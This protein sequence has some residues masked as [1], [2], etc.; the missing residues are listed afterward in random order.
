CP[1]LYGAAPPF[2]PTRNR[3]RSVGPNLSNRQSR[4]PI[5][6]WPGHPTWDESGAT[7]LSRPPTTDPATP[8]RIRRI[9]WPRHGPASPP[10]PPTDTFGRPC[11][12]A[13]WSPP[14]WLVHRTPAP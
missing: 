14:P 2:Q 11:A 8:W 12:V 10:P 13:D 6:R 1:I 5:R 4:Q 7:A 9:R 3:P